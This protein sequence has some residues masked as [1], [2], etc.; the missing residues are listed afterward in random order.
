MK[1]GIVSR[2]LAGLGAA[3]ALLACQPTED[4]VGASDSMGLRSFESE[5][6]LERFARKMERRSRVDR[7]QMPAPMMDVEEPAAEAAMADAGEGESITNTQ[8]AGVDE[9]GIVKRS[10]NFLIVLRRGRV[11][12]IRHGDNDLSPVSAIDAYPPGKESPDST[13]YDEM[14]VHEG[15]VIVIGY[16]YGDFGTE[17]NRFRLSD[18][19]QLSY[20][21]THYLRSG[22]YYSSSN[23]A[24][25]LI[26]NELILYAPLYTDWG[27]WRDRLP[28]LRKGGPDGEA[29]T[30]VE[31][32]SLYVAEPYRDGEYSLEVLH[33]VTRCNLA[34][35]DLEC[36]AS[37]IAG[38]WG[39]A[40]YVSPDSVYVW[41]APARRHRHSSDSE[42]TPGQIYRIPLDGSR[43]GAVAAEGAPVD[44][45][46]FSEDA[47]DGVLR[48]VLR[49]DGYGEGMWAGE[50]SRGDT[51]LVT[52]KFSDFGNGGQSLDR[53]AYRKLPRV[54]GWRFHNRFVGDW[55]LYAAGDYGDE[56]KDNFVYAVPLK[57]GDVTKVD[58]PHGVTRFDRLG[59]DG[60]VIGPGPNGALGFSALALSDEAKLEATYMM[61]AAS[62][63]ETRSQAFFFRPDRGAEDGKS[64]TLGLPVSRRV[65]RDGSEFLGSGSAIA[66]LRR[67][68]RQM[69]PAGEL[70]ARSERARPDNCKASCTDWYGNA[71]PIF[72]GDRVFA[73]MGYELVEGRFDGGQILEVRRIDYGPTGR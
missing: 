30:L 24:S 41:T 1:A 67:E 26:G 68:N 44:Q 21:D 16:S 2:T 37:A 25:R 34:L 72:L 9:G 33:A 45:F 54:D 47:E 31:P 6:T 58:L 10:G 70:A 40:F 23:Y 20:R 35:A 69:R 32:E 50:Y 11:F 3:S 52:A 55:L 51:A 59:I 8:E 73:L 38:S 53:S 65:E 29:I 42:R 19:G 62:E 13:W 17:I 27:N 60:V 43:P 57:G 28:A 64:G 63:G 49:E 66:F 56:A 18:D 14:L 12:T 15:N 22:D 61:A 71:R 39:H 48:V 46:A 7:L 4:L 5:A 36:S